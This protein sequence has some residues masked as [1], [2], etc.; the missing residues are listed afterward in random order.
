MEATL[1]QRRIGA[2]SI[3]AALALVCAFWAS[4][5]PQSAIYKN[6]KQDQKLKE[7]LRSIKPPEGTRNFKID[8]IR[9][10]FEGKSF[11]MVFGDFSTDLTC[12]QVKAH[13]K[14]E[15]ARHGFAFN[16]KDGNDGENISNFY[17][18][19]AEHNAT[20][21]CQESRTKKTQC[22]IFLSETTYFSLG[23]PSVPALGAPL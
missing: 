4:S 8:T 5:I 3:I 16:D 10:N 22:T 2:L 14:A 23:S 13:Y 12:E 9:N 21:G 11:P 7:M 18:S 17:F 19:N 1:K 15:F 20:V 6:Y